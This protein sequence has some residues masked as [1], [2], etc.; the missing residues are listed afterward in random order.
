[1]DLIQKAAEQGI[2]NNVE[3]PRIKCKIFEDNA[4]AV[5]LANVP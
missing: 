4:G 5:E 1:V 3:T 2:I